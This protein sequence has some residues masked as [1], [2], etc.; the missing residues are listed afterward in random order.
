MHH[1][2]ILS[3]SWLRESLSLPKRSRLYPLKPYGLGTPWVESLSSYITRLAAIHQ[4]ATGVLLSQEL[5]PFL[6]KCDREQRLSTK[7][8]QTFFSQTGAWNGTGM[9]ATEPMSVLQKLTQQPSLR[10]LTL[11]T[12][13]SVLSTKNLLRPHKAWCPLCY[14]EWNK[15][16]QIVHDP[17]LWCISAITTC[18]RHKQ[19][20]LNLCPNCGEMIYELSWNSKVGFCCRCHYWLGNNCRVNNNINIKLDDW[21]WQ[22]FINQQIGSILAN[23]PYLIQLP[24]LD[25]LANAIDFC[26][27]TY[28]RGNASYFAE[29]MFLSPTVPLDWRQG[30][31]L[32]SLNLLL[33]VCY[34]LSIPLIDILTGNV[35][36]LEPQA[37]K[38]LP[39][40]QQ[41]RKTNRPFTLNTVQQLL[42]NAL[43]EEPPKSVMEVAAAISYHKTELYRHFPDLCRQITTRYKLYRYQS[44]RERV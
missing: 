13:S 24:C 11:I 2:Y 23:A 14:E 3:E 43:I 44:Q 17:L 41:Q 38:E 1:E 18:S 37:L 16:T 40:C 15:N 12:W 35:K 32:P 26:I 6:N 19:I 5:A 36:V 8:Y 30:R 42:E 9:M 28:G 22:N 7:Y 21:E 4:V 39:L 31:T 33:R 20:L 25:K 27:Q 10:F 34:R 29:Q